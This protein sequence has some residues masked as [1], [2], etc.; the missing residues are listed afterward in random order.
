MT[1]LYLLASLII[2]I[3]TPETGADIANAIN[4]GL[5]TSIAG[6]AMWFIGLIIAMIID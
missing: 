3:F 4:S 1:F 6:L 2:S 5:G